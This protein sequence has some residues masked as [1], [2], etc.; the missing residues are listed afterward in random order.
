MSTPST[1]LAHPRIGLLGATWAIA[2]VSVLLVGG[3]F[4]VLP[5]ALELEWATLGWLEWSGLSAFVVFMAIGK[6]YF[7]FHRSFAPRT[8][9]RALLLARETGLLRV[10]LA[11]LYAMC[12][13]QAPRPRLARSWALVLA[14][15]AIVPLVSALPQP[16]RGI[17]DIGVIVGLGL[18]VSSFWW[19]LARGLR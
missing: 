3:V 13:I 6:G 17:V 15:A 14:I 18:G 4:S 10:V 1:S 5:H 19:Y 9:E 16:W 2:G 8:A 7:G 11:P 12:L